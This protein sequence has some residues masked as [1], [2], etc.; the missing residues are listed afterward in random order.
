[1]VVRFATTYAISAYH[2]YSCEFE[3]HSW[4][5]VHDTALCDKI[6]Q[7]LATVGDF[8]WVLW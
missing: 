5:G 8:L 7:W 6:C 1:M 3:P 4:Q 2:Y